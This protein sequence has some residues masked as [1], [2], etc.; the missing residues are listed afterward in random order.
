MSR[1]LEKRN[2]IYG[3]CA[4]WIV[5]FH[6]FRRIG[7][8][9]IPVVTNVIAVGNM[10]VDIFF[11]FSGLCLSLSAK[12]HNYQETGW[13][14]FF[15][16]R[17]VRVA[18]PYF[19]ICVPYYLWN[20]ICEKSGGIVH[21]AAVF[22]FN[23]SSVSFWLKGTQTTWYVYGILVFYLLFPLLYSFMIKNGWKRRAE[24]S[25]GLI[26]FA[27]VTSYLPILR[28]S[29]LVW[30]RLPIFTAGIIAGIEKER[31]KKPRTGSII[32]SV[33]LLL[34]L[35]ALTSLSEMREDFNIPQV[36][37]LLLYLPMTIAL[38]VLMSTAGGKIQIFEWMGSL[39]LEIYLIHITLLHPIKYYG[40]M[41]AVGYGLYLILPAVSVFLAWIV[42]KIEKLISPKTNS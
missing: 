36:Y 26:V 2:T 39:S 17:A 20:A 11:F 24:L 40:V 14:T 38:L 15:V 22:F 35:G 31:I 30:I 34:V 10:A 41:D 21:Q 8:P 37:R 6:T 25:V 28:N 4:I 9:Y 16:R 13:K 1:L 18:I 19:I 5:M 29:L 27:I 32:V 3:L 33:V 7:M 12:K 42:G 23:L